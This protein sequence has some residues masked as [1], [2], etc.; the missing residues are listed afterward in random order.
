MYELEATADLLVMT[1]QGKTAI[2]RR[3]L[4]VLPQQSPDLGRVE[5]ND[6]LESLE[7]AFVRAVLAGN[8]EVFGRLYEL[9]AP[10]VHGVLLARL[11]RSE[12]EDMV[13]EIFLHALRKLDTLRD[14]NAF[15]PWIAMIA[16]NRAMD[17]HRKSRATVAVDDCAEELQSRDSSLSKAEEI[18]AIIRTLPDAYRETLVLRLVEGMTGPEIATRTGLTAASVRVN[19]HRGM[20]LLRTKLGF[21][22]ACYEHRQ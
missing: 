14:A 22:E 1:G 21:Q 16:R 11:P 13:Q 9:Y 17:F 10:L 15:G 20:K 4:E 19:L 12:V 6:S 2:D 5:S 7:S 3:P 18:L 8:R